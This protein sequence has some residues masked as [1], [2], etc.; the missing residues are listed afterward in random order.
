MADS[1][2]GLPAFLRLLSSHPSGNDVA[3]S[4]N[5]GL[6]GQ[7]HAHSTTIWML[8]EREVLSLVGSAGYEPDVLERWHRIPLSVQSQ[9]VEVVRCNDIMILPSSELPSRYSTTQ[10]SRERY[11]RILEVRGSGE[12]VGIP[13]VHQGLCLGVAQFMTSEPRIWTSLEYS[14][15]SGVSAALGLWATHP[16]TPITPLYIASQVETPL[17]LS[18]RQKEIID[19]VL[20][21]VGNNQIARE[22]LVSVSTVKQELQKIMRATSQSDRVAAARCAVE[23]GLV[24]L[25]A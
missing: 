4:L 21:G 23:M 15:L 24:E 14:V 10:F 17:I 9:M 12:H 5:E 25:P 20:H 13:V 19:L 6:F 7:F 11:M 22:L 3:L 1:A 8:E 2:L 16:D 18:E